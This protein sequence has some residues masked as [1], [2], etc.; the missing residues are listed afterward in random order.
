[1]KRL[2]ILVAALFVSACGGNNTPVEPELPV[3]T[4][5]QLTDFYYEDIFPGN[6]VITTSS[7]TFGGGPAVFVLRDDS[8]GVLL[9]DSTL[10]AIF[11]DSLSSTTT[12]VKILPSG[13]FSF[14]YTTDLE[15]KLSFDVGINNSSLWVYNVPAVLSDSAITYEGK[16]CYD[17]PNICG[18][19]IALQAVWFI[20]SN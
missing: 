1:M 14:V 19:R 4:S 12:K 2:C 6:W 17:D 11:V 5:Y 16:V 13:N 20:I 15:N 9:V 10:T 8:T 7:D 18:D 3:E